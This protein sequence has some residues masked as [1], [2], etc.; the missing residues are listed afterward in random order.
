MVHPSAEGF[1]EVPLE[2]HQWRWHDAVEAKEAF[3][4]LCE[5]S[6][7]LRQR[8]IAAELPGLAIAAVWWSMS[9]RLLARLACR[10]KSTGILP[11]IRIGMASSNRS[12]TASCGVAT[13]SWWSAIVAD[14][15]ASSVAWQGELLWPREL[16][17]AGII[18]I[19]A[20]TGGR[21]TSTRFRER[22]GPQ[23]RG[24]RIVAVRDQLQR[25][26][27]PVLFYRSLDE[28]R[29]DA[30]VSRV[31]A[32]CCGRGRHERRRPTRPPDD[33]DRLFDELA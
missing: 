27:I 3:D 21:G 31:N 12:A 13:A 7:D 25:F 6:V 8:R 4:A 5:S 23:G 24:R 16:P 1:V 15:S 29:D 11:I 17:D 22:P 19:A 2:V 9:S 30:G 33:M 20:V 10:R 26:E 18:D 32:R 28:C 14:R